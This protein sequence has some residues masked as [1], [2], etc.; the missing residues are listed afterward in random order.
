MIKFWKAVFDLLARFAAEAIEDSFD[1]EVGVMETG[2]IS[3]FLAAL[4]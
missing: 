1:D 2:Q 3:Y 4:H